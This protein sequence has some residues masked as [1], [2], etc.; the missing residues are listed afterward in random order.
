METATLET[1][2]NMKPVQLL[3][4][5]VLAVGHGAVS[6]SLRRLVRC[7]ILLALVACSKATPPA[8][9]ADARVIYRSAD[10]RELKVQDLDGANGMVKWELVGATAVPPEATALHERGRAAGAKGD[11]AKSIELL[12]AAHEKAPDWPY[13]L[14]DLAFTYE[15]SGDEVKAEE[16]Y[17]IVDKLAP[18]GFFTAKTSLDCLRRQRSG[19]L[20]PGLCKAYASL[21][22]MND[23]AEKKRAVEG[24][25]K[26]VPS[27]AP[28]WK[29]LAVL[30]DD[31]ADKMRAIEQ[32]LSHEPDPETKGVLLIN[33]A[34]V[35]DGRGDHAGADRILGELA[36]DPG[37]TLSTEAMAKATLSLLT[38]KR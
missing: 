20:P 37:S 11:Y 12:E 6:V 21:E 18:R 32:G 28:A 36:L 15:L 1:P 5:P 25:T 27:Y 38:R 2:R 22:W 24:I 23:E 33:K 10:G 30:L 31:P 7:G 34:I 3:L 8:P 4:H 17:A 14:Y 19:A 13:P 26:K 35:L 16:Q 9:G 29:A